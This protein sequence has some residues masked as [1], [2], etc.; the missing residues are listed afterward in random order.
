MR[1]SRRLP[2]CQLGSHGGACALARPWPLLH[3]CRERMRLRWLL[4]AGPEGAARPGRV[5]WPLRR[6]GPGRLART[7]P[8]R[9][10]THCRP[11]RLGAAWGVGRRARARTACANRGM[12]VG[13]QGALPL[14]V[15]TEQEH[16][17]SGAQQQCTYWQTHS[18]A[19]SVGYGKGLHV[20][21]ACKTAHAVLLMA[22]LCTSSCAL[23]TSGPSTV[24]PRGHSS[25]SPSHSTELR[26]RST[27]LAA[28]EA[29][30]AR[31]SPAAPCRPRTQAAAAPHRPPPPAPASPGRAAAAAAAP[32]W[33]VAAG[34]P[35]ARPAGRS[36]RVAK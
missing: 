14:L 19:R 12:H 31:S 20:P 26:M 27:H 10:R 34:R 9:C 13:R 2:S 6:I 21:P 25:L 1:V 5:R 3:R 33:P 4:Q 29:A 8:P 7:A 24:S 18:E 36:A 22:R 30:R 32:A 15:C 11:G 23:Q 28:A 17:S 16:R 35:A